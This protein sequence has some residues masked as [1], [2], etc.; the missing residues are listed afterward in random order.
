MPDIIVETLGCI[1]FIDTDDG[2]VGVTI[3]TFD[4][5][6]CQLVLPISVADGLHDG[7]FVMYRVF[8]D[9]DTL[10]HVITRTDAPKMSAEEEAKVDTYID[11]VINRLKENG[12]FI[13]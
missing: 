9:D 6:S 13:D 7:D 3:R 1:D 10:S 8:S 2:I 12:F 5:G 4:G 11:E